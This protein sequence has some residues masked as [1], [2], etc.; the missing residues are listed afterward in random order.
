MRG[1]GRMRENKAWSTSACL[2]AMTTCPRISPCVL[3]FGFNLGE[4]TLVERYE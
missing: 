1:R 3:T 4:Q 2:R